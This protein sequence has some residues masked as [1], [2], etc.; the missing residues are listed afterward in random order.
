MPFWRS[1]PMNSSIVRFEWPMVQTSSG[2][3]LSFRGGVT[4]I[5][6]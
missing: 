3:M 1:N 6:A 2:V 4:H 5:L